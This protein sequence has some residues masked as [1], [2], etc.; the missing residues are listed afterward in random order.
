MLD[1]NFFED[2]EEKAADLCE[3]CGEREAE[4]ERFV[5]G[6]GY[7]RLCSKCAFL[8]FAFFMDDG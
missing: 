1:D 8:F 7:L 6:S 5:P 2:T 3:W 4:K